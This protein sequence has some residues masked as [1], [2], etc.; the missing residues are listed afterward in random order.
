V[1]QEQLESTESV[2]PLVFSEKLVCQEREANLDQSE[3]PALLVKTVVSDQL[4]H[5]EL[6]DPVE[7]KENV[8]WVEVQE[9]LD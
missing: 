4:D 9:L 1:P 5:P 3:L 2:V 6:P 7:V 8:E